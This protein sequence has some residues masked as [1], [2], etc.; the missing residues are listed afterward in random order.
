M[1]IHSQFLLNHISFSEET[2][3][4]LN[5]KKLNIN[6]MIRYIFFFISNFILEYSCGFYKTDY[7]K[8]GERHR[9]IFL[10]NMT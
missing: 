7:F 9:T 4:F 8:R 3:Y 2:L 5:G 10:N 6:F 1:N